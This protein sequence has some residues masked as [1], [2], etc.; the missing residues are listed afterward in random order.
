MEQQVT[1]VGAGLCGSLLAFYLARRGLTVQLFERLPDM[2]NE[3]VPAGRSI[4]LVL[5]QR[6]VYALHEV[7][8]ENVIT[9]LLIPMRGRMIHEPGQAPAFQP[10]GKD[11]SEVI[12]SISRAALNMA[13]LDAA[14]STGRVHLQ[15][16]QRCID[17]DL[18]HGATVFQHK[19]TGVTR[20]VESTPIIGT[21]GANSEV[22][23]AL[24]RRGL[25][26][27][28]SL[29]LDHSYKELT[30]PPTYDGAF[31]L[32][33]EALHIWPRTRFMLIAL[34]NTDASFTGTLFLPN[35]G[36][37]SFK[38]LVSESAV[39]R[40]FESM[41]PDAHSLMPT[42]VQ[43]FFR[44][45]KGVLGTVRSKPWHV[46]G[47]VLLMGDAAHA[48][49]PFHGQGMNCAFEDCSALNDCIER[50]APDWNTVFTEFENMRLANANA[51]ADMALENYVEMR[52]SVRDPRF[53]LKK[54]LE[55]VLERRYPNRFIPRY[56]MVMFHRIP[57][58]E[59]YKRGEIQAHILDELTE[60]LGD[61]QR[62]N[63]NLADRLIKDKLAPLSRASH[64]L[65]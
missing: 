22:R 44:N 26:G 52:D 56:S 55:R 10:Y 27:S 32:E 24:E 11:E 41:F 23:Q 21:D 17:V 8:L 2:R 43:D 36:E 62:V 51:I 25:L 64:V 65:G 1:I 35:E 3:P 15:F 39:T 47:Q 34:P 37:P 59:A 29:L 48:V 42:L 60:A 63:L 6:G 49:V 45:P 18:E 46:R 38:S 58:A 5:A 19:G 7:G 20:L 57:Y 14:E 4:N 53:H 12:Y 31:Q 9:P 54:A 33:S 13:L 28:E 40:F 16:K 30:I 61:V 50:H